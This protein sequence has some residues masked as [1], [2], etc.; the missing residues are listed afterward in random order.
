MGGL[1]E[2]TVEYGME[3]NPGKSK[4]VS[5]TRAWLEDPM[6]YSVLDQAIPEASGCKYCT[7][8]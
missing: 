3:I 6:N 1:G 5:F 2:W 4:A 7:W 8:E